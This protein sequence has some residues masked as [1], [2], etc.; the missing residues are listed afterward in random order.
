MHQRCASVIE[1]EI[2]GVH[3][4]LDAKLKK[5]V[6]HKIGGLDHYTPRK[7]RPAL[8]GRVVLTEDEGKAKNRFSC[9]AVLNFPH[10]V[11]AAK[12]ATINIYA[13]VDIVEAKLKNQLKKYK[14]KRL[15]PR[16]GRK[17]GRVRRFLGKLNPRR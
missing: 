6:Q 7:S 13:A 4:E 10:G 15:S 16:S 2:A 1:L 9:E 12:E 11:I 14:E 3:F 17:D 8:H 5:Y